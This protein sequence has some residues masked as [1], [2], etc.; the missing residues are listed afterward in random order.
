MSS[1]A[2]IPLQGTQPTFASPTQSLSQAL[3]LR[4][5]AGQLQLRQA[6]A[7][8]Y[9]AKAAAEQK[10]QQDQSTIQSTLADPAAYQRLHSGDFS[11]FAGKVSL[12]ALGKLQDYHKQQVETAKAQSDQEIKERTEALGEVNKT[13]AGIAGI[14]NP[15]GTPNLQAQQQAW[16]PAIANLDAAGVLKRGKINTGQIPQVLSSPD[17]IQQYAAQI[18]G[19]LSLQEQARAAK[20]QEAKTNK[21]SAAGAKDL[22]E[23]QIKNE[24][25]AGMQGGLLPDEIVK[26]KQATA[27]LAETRSRDQALAA[28]ERSEDVHAR[29]EEGQK[30]REFEANYGAPG[31]TGTVAALADALKKGRVDFQTV[32]RMKGG[33]AALSQALAEDPSLTEQRYAGIKAFETG[34]DAQDLSTL[35]M[36]DSHLSSLKTASDAQ[37]LRINPYSSEAA[38]LGTVATDVAGV[39]GKLV[40]S[41]ALTKGEHDEYMGRLNSPLPNVREAAI[42]GMKE[43]LDGKKEAIAEKFKGSTGMDLPDSAMNR[44]ATTLPGGHTV[45]SSVTLKNGK[46]VKITA[47]HPDGTFD[48]Q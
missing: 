47:I 44:P 23:T 20:E 9:Q 33:Q 39:M 31:D 14:K 40:K 26:N 5:M 10:A 45:G 38:K 28:H 21:D 27:T 25:Y 43:M 42:A 2:M 16:G 30:Q 34:K 13:L 36:L 6:Q 29:V 41:G 46:T 7:A 11:D 18:G 17:Q 37:G 4:D 35:H 12:G 15:D 24:Q 1:A 19:A 48:A 3:Q 32:K 22:A 8:E